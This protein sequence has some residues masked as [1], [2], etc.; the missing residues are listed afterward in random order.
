M[1]GRET[2]LQAFLNE[3]FQETISNILF[4]ALPLIVFLCRNSHHGRSVY[5]L[6][7]PNS[8]N[9]FFVILMNSQS[10]V[11]AR[12]R[13]SPNSGRPTAETYVGGDSG[14]GCGEGC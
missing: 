2:L 9:T 14:P 3:S 11:N 6:I 10:S 1:S 13:L 8:W 5:R 7:N 4:T 12:T